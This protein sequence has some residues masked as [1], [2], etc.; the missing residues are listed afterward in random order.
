MFRVERIDRYNGRTTV[1]AEW[2]YRDAGLNWTRAVSFLPR[3]ARVWVRVDRFGDV[4][5][6]YTSHLSD[7]C[8]A[9]SRIGAGPLCVAHRE[10]EPTPEPITAIS[11]IHEGYK[12]TSDTGGYTWATFA[13]CWA[14][15]DIRDWWDAYGRLATG[16]EFDGFTGG[17]GQAF[18]YPAVIR[19]TA[20]RTLVTQFSGLDV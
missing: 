18:A 17:P 10:P 3:D 11:S 13:P 19:R 14:D 2:D 6:S 20:T 8:P 7:E 16:L 1:D 9:C 4:V 5:V 15:E 12:R